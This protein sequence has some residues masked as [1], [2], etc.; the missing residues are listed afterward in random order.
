MNKL[1][2]IKT[3]GVLKDIIPEHEMPTSSP[4][5]LFRRLDRKYP[6]WLEYSKYCIATVNGEE[7]VDKNLHL[8]GI[9]GEVL[10]EIFPK[11]H[12]NILDFFQGLLTS[13]GTLFGD[14]VGAVGEVA[15]AIGG[16][17]TGIIGGIFGLILSIFETED[18]ASPSSSPKIAVFSKSDNVDKQGAIIP[19]V[20]GDEV[21]SGSVIV[22]SRLTPDG[23][24]VGNTNFGA[25]G[26]EWLLTSSADV[27]DIIGHDVIINRLDVTTDNDLDRIREGILFG[28]TPLSVYEIDKVTGDQGSQNEFLCYER[29]TTTPKLTFYNYPTNVESDPEFI[30]GAFNARWANTYRFV[31]SS[32]GTFNFPND[33]TGSSIVNS[34]LEWDLPVDADIQPV[35][36][37][38]SSPSVDSVELLFNTSGSYVV[39]PDDPTN[40]SSFSLGGEVKRKLSTGTTWFSVFTNAFIFSSTDFKGN[41]ATQFNLPRPIVTSDKIWDFEFQFNLLRTSRYVRDSKD[42]TQLNANLKFLG[43][44]EVLN[45]DREVLLDDNGLTTQ[46]NQI[47][48]VNFVM[49]AQYFGNNIPKREYLLAGQPITNLDDN[50]TSRSSNP[51]RQIYELLTNTTFGGAIP[52]TMIDE[53]SFISV[54]EYCEETIGTQKR[55]TSNFN[56]TGPRSLQ[57][58]FKQMGERIGASVYKNKDNKV[59]ITIDRPRT[60]DRIIG[61]GDLI[62]EGIKVQEVAEN[63]KLDEVK[64]EFKNRDSFYATEYTT[65]QNPDLSSIKNTV[66]ISAFNTVFREEAER[67]GAKLLYNNLY[68]SDVY[69]CRVGPAFGN[70]EIGEVVLLADNDNARRQFSGKLSSSS[71]QSSYD[72]MR[73]L[74]LDTPYA[75]QGDLVLDVANLRFFSF[76]DAGKACSQSIVF[77]S[78]D[79]L[80]IRLSSSLRLPEGD[81]TDTGNIQNIYNT[82]GAVTYTVHAGKSWIIC[83][84]PSRWVNPTTSV[85]P[86]MGKVTKKTISK[87]EVI[88]LTLRQ[89][90]PFI[91]RHIDRNTSFSAIAASRIYSKPW[92][93]RLNGG[94]ASSNPV[95][96]FSGIGA[97]PGFSAVADGTSTNDDPANWTKFSATFVRNSNNPV[98]GGTQDYLLAPTGTTGAIAQSP[99]LTIPPG[100]YRLSFDYN[101]PSSVAANVQA[102]EPFINGLSASLPAGSSGSIITGNAFALSS[103]TS[104]IFVSLPAGLT[105]DTFQ[106]NNIILT[107]IDTTSVPVRGGNA[108]NKAFVE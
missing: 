59:A 11:V 49:S 79:G 32:V 76:D 1:I 68:T 9:E 46:D 75:P 102:L 86:R 73:T 87:S 63:E 12:G 16:A 96:E 93:S 48:F 94:N 66:S 44:N 41:A 70:I 23:N 99:T 80:T 104:N 105:T 7:I 8:A 45:S 89:F 83:E 88:Q 77:I 92:F 50:S 43:W 60:I 81:F 2:K 34:L 78:Q 14:V 54:D 25:F 51:S 52:T 90:D 107:Q 47:S 72:N 36:G 67:V 20:F 15:G 30:P 39:D 35:I 29:G 85:L 6:D 18:V 71:T 26:T 22:R 40:T 55:W 98:G 106:I 82:S 62:G 64:I 19:M 37:T 91:F 108:S 65:V 95:I 58:I 42:V 97:T 53:T 84:D 4:Y 74:T 3:Y 38:I 101:N 61:N 24:Q 33:A 69:T 27:T 10:V 28:G 5:N 100:T 21:R 31:G 56:I 13:V 57:K 103:I 17:V